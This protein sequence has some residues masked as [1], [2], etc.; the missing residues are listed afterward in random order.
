MARAAVEQ[1]AGRFRGCLPAVTAEDHLVTVLPI[2]F[3]VEPA[4]GIEDGAG[5]VPGGVLRRFADIDEF[6]LPEV[7]AVREFVRADRRRGLHVVV[8]HGPRVHHA[9]ARRRRACP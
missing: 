9:G 5:Y 6:R 2:A 4:Q 1:A 8:V 3:R 7:Q